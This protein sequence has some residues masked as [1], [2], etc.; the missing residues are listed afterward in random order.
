MNLALSILIIGVCFN[1]FVAGLVSLKRQD[2]SARIL[3]L[4]AA[5]LIAW[6]VANYLEIG[7]AHV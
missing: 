3:G 5:G 4:V 7:R 6:E 2:S 1:L